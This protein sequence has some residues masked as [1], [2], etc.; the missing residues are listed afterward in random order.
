MRVTLEMASADVERVKGCCAPVAAP[1]EQPQAAG[2]SELFKALADPA[3]V[4][5][6]HMLKHATAPVCVCDFT[7]VLDLEQPTISHHLARL[8]RAGLV[9]AERQGIWSFFG[10]D[11]EMSVAARSAIDLID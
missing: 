3:R 6:L 11:P 9:R 7:A 5:M 1:L 10:L 2:L 4:Q 8:R